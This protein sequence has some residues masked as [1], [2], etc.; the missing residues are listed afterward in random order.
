VPLSVSTQVW[1]TLVAD[2]V[3]THDSVRP[4]VTSQSMS[5]V[6]QSMQGNIHDLNGKGR[7]CVLPV[8]T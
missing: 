3:D 6:S 2:T 5:A 1:R 7:N 8:S 4:N